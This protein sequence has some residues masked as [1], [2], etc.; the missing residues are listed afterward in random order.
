VQQANL[1]PL[2]KGKGKKGKLLPEG[3]KHRVAA[4]EIRLLYLAIGW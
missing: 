4:V 1:S 2:I 3:A